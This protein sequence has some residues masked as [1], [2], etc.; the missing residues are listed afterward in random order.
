MTLKPI[1]T[2]TVGEE[3]RS[4]EVERYNLEGEIHVVVNDIFWYMDKNCTEENGGIYKV[5]FQDLFDVYKQ[6]HPDKTEDDWWNT[7]DS[8]GLDNRWYRLSRHLYN[9]CLR[10]K[11]EG[12]QI[13]DE[14]VSVE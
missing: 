1:S 12:K 3:E 4:Y 11:S 7:F 2:F 13:A 8:V 5:T 9:A 6:I 14:Y 10:W